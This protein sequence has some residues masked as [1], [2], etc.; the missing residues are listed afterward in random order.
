MLVASV[1]VAA[2]VGARRALLSTVEARLD[3]PDRRRTR[4]SDATTRV[5]VGDAAGVRTRSSTRLWAA[6]ARSVLAAQ[7]V[8]VGAGVGCGIAIG[9]TSGW[10]EA[11]LVM[12]VM[13]VS[14][15][16]GDAAARRSPAR[17]LELASPIVA[18]ASG[19]VAPLTALSSAL[20]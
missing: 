7:V 20:S 4:R 17:V 14:A 1:L 16:A 3:D 9:T 19:V 6:P 11:V 2:S 13:G 10:S 12:V 18:L 8:V 5:G 15:A